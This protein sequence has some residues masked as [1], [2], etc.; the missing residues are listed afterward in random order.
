MVFF[1]MIPSRFGAE[2]EGIA[3]E[4]QA[5]DLDLFIYF[6]FWE[7]G[8]ICLHRSCAKVTKMCLS[9]P[10]KSSLWTGLL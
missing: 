10:E 2:G 6:S 8:T 3:L 5:S 9:P 4:E 7:N 1:P